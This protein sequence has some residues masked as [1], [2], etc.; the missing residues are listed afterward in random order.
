MSRVLRAFAAFLV[1]C[2][3][4]HAALAANIVFLVRTGTDAEGNPLFRQADSRDTYLGGLFELTNNSRAMHEVARYYDQVQR[5]K[6]SASLQ[7]RGLSQQDLQYAMQNFKA[8]PVYIEVNNS[9]AGAYNDWKGRF[10]VQWGNGQVGTY[11]TPRVVFSLGSEVARS[12]NR[13]LIEQTLVHE[14]AHGG[15][16]QCHGKNRLPETPWLSRPHSGGSVTDEQLAYIEGWAEFV[17]A[18]FT[19]RR[20]IAEDP[21][22][23]IDTN[24]YAKRADGSMK[25][26]Q[27]LVRTEG[28]NATIL[29]K[30]ATEA[31]DQNAMWK[32]T[33]AASR[34]AP[35]STMQ[36][37]QITAQYFP[38]LATT[39]NRVVSQNSG[40]QIPQVVQGGGQY[41]N[42]G[43]QGGYTQ[44]ANY[45]NGGGVDRLEQAL[46]G[47]G[48]GAY[49]GYQNYVNHQNT[50]YGQGQ[51]SA[52]AVYQDTN[53]LMALYQQ[54]R[55]QL[56]AVPWWK[57]WEKSKIK[58]ELAMIEDLYSRQTQLAQGYGYAAAP[59]A[60]SQQHQQVAPAAPVA[61]KK[62]YNDAVD[63][64]K[65][66][67]SAGA[68]SS[69]DAHRR[70]FESRK[71]AR[72]GGAT[73]ER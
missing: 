20:T 10:S 36:L 15:M 12:G 49:S 26:A 4:A 2:V 40:G 8:D 63:A 59:T 43:N 7:G 51:T 32:M 33:Q 57:F 29:Y 23:A 62:T 27:E 41:A 45:Q 14:V 37:L 30:I 61:S 58:E 60:P 69:L 73:S 64:L 52:G 44:P 16:C 48:S 9:A 67:D 46:Y 24:W 47:G 53:Q 31:R 34:G 72:Q 39:I 22:N 68:A 66:N 28:W 6:L 70:A 35:Q 5:D 55:A 65:A 17:G 13:A 56:D 21:A 18:Y 38:E 54:K 3:A 42:Y 11:S 25:S 50:G 71:A 1:F 19:G